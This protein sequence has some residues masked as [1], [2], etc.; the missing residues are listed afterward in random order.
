MCGIASRQVGAVYTVFEDDAFLVHLPRYVRS[1][2]QI[3]VI[4]KV[5]ATSFDDLG[6]DAWNRTA[7]LA[8]VASQ[9]QRRLLTPLR[10]FLASTGSAGGEKLNTSEH[11]HM[12]VVPVFDANER[13]RDIFSWRDGVYV[14]EAHEWEDLERACQAAWRELT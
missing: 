2:G 14:A 13:P 9:V 4:P 12:H 6:R 5:H 3:T 1:W 7:D 11:V 10:T 8:Y